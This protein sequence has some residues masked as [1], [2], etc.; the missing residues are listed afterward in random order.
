M[1]T[2]S[3]IGSI[4]VLFALLFYSIGFYQIQRKRIVDK[5]VLFAYILGLALDISA[6]C[7]MILG[8]TKGLFTFHGA[9]GYSA[10]LG[11]GVDTFL[12]WKHYAQN[13]TNE[14]VKPNLKLYS[15][16]AYAWWVVA[17]VTGGL[18]VAFSHMK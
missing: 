16:I 12:L 4:V 8:S 3:I 13:R 14:S 1:K 6:T 11:M 18:M 17:F 15:R 7:L 10:L 5:R 9:L 2:F